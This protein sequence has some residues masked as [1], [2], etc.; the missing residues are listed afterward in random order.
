MDKGAL[1]G[2]KAKGHGTV[3]FFFFIKLNTLTSPNQVFTCNTHI[4]NGY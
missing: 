3:C 4:G 1:S 2:F